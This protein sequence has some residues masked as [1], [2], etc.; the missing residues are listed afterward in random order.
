VFRRGRLIGL[1]RWGT[2]AGCE[3]V[4]RHR[5]G[6][7]LLARYPALA[8]TTPEPLWVDEETEAILTLESACEGAAPRPGQ[9]GSWTGAEAAAEWLAGL[10]RLTLQS[11]AGAHR[12]RTDLAAAIARH[13]GLRPGTRE[14]VL[15]RLERQRAPVMTA[16]HGDL[17]WGNLL[18]S[19][20]GG[21]AVVDWSECREFEHPWHDV[22][23][24]LLTYARDSLG[25]GHDAS[26]RRWLT[27][28]FRK[29]AESWLQRYN[30]A[31]PAPLGWEE[32]TGYAPLMMARYACFGQQ[33]AA[34]TRALNAWFLV[35]GDGG[36][37]IEP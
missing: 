30:Q 12:W 21:L 25:G 17:W 5:R 36:R 26:P 6:L 15:G 19:R 9:A 22:A 1:A 8:A 10:Q 31:S 18:V 2:G 37:L 35:S 16:A 28:T 27:E 13:E 33:A 4:R 32:L 11:G 3:L 24:F 29:A 34:W 23:F 7:E 20:G 14:R